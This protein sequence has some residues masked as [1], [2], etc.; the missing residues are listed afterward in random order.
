MPTPIKSLAKSHHLTRSTSNHILIIGWHLVLCFLLRELQVPKIFHTTRSYSKLKTFY[1]FVSIVTLHLFFLT[2]LSRHLHRVYALWPNIS[3]EPMYTIAKTFCSNRAPRHCGPGTNETHDSGRCTKVHYTKAVFTTT[4]IQEYYSPQYWER[5]ICKWAFTLVNILV[6]RPTINI[7]IKIHL[8]RNQNII[9]N[10]LIF[11]Y[12]RDGRLNTTYEQK[13]TKIFFTANI[14]IIVSILN[15]FEI[16]V[17]T[18]QS[19]QRTCVI[20]CICRTNMRAPSAIIYVRTR[21]VCIWW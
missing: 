2:L 17:K 10:M 21:P 8:I 16:V 5:E 20:N 3:K 9:I 18:R 19:A 14:Q 4:T 11:Y 13:K 6:S 15:N 7:I 12:V 1:H